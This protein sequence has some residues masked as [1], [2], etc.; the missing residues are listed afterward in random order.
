MRLVE[1][2]EKAFRDKY[3]KITDNQLKNVHL[4][5]DI[6]FLKFND[7]LNEQTVNNLALIAN[8]HPNHLMDLMSLHD[9]QNAQLREKQEKLEQASEK[10]AEEL[11]EKIRKVKR[12]PKNK[13]E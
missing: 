8:V 2:Y 9:Q 11:P 4:L 12:G 10:I 13:V 6:M 7:I 3:E 5:M 1:N